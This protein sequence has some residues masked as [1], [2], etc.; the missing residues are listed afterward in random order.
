MRAQRPEHSRAWK[1]DIQWGMR[2]GATTGIGLFI[3]V[4]IAVIA[5]I[6]NKTPYGFSVYE[7][8]GFY[9]VGGLA[10][11]LI[12]GLMR[13]LASTLLGEACIGFVVFLPLAFMIVGRSRLERSSDLPGWLLALG[14]CA[15]LGP[16]YAISFRLVR[17]HYFKPE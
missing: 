1:R 6:N 15:L 12:L 5:G 4:L 14:A 13:P 16:F 17:K 11:G 9:I 10:G 7:L 8:A 3:I 2:W